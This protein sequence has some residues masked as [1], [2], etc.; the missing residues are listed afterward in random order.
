LSGNDNP[1]WTRGNQARVGRLHTLPN[2][3]AEVARL[4]RSVVAGHIE[5]AEATRRVFI[6]RELRCCLEAENLQVILE[7]LERLDVLAGGRRYGYQ[8]PDRPFV[9][10]H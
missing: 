4:Y 2:V 8:A 3:R 5:S 1:K 10:P 6:L 9:R 7:R